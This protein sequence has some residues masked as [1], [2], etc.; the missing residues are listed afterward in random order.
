MTPQDVRERVE[1]I[2][3]SS[4]DDENAH[5]MEDALHRD[6]LAAIADWQPSQGTLEYRALCQ[7]ALKTMEIDFA[8]WC[9]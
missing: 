8:R 3:R 5:S 2:R 6:V 4:Q 7:E 1:E 9:A